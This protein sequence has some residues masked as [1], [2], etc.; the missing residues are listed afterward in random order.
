MND[1]SIYRSAISA[2]VVLYVAARLWRLTDSCLWFDEIFSVHAAE[3]SWTG[4][5]SFVAVDLIH[6]P[7]FYILLKGWIGIGGESLPWLRSLPV[8][9]SSVALI[10][11]VFLCKEFA[12]RR[13]SIVLA[14]LFFGCNG[15]LIKYSQEVRMYGLLLCLGLFSIWLFLR[16]EKKGKGIGLLTI[17]N[18]LLVYT[19]YAG[20]LTI[21][22]EVLVVLL[23]R[24]DLAKRVILSTTLV[25][26]VFVPW[27]FAV[28]NASVGG[29]GFA[30]NIGWI[31]RPGA[32]AI[33]Q[34]LLNLCEPF[35]SQVSSIDP[36]S[37]YQVTIPILLLAAIAVT[38]STAQRRI[39][40][41]QN[42]HSLWIF[43]V[44]PIIVMFLASW[45]FPYSIWGV[46]HLIVVFPLG[47]IILAKAIEG[48]RSDWMRVGCIT[49]IVLFIGYGSV[50]QIQRAA[51]PQIWCAWEQ[52]AAQIPQNRQPQRL[53]VFEDLNA[54]HF[55]FATRRRSDIQIIKVNDMPEMIEDK[56]YFLPRGFSG[57]QTIDREAIAGDHFWIAFRDMKWDERHPPLNI[58]IA[59]GY[60]IGQPAWVDAQGLKAFLAEVSR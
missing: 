30:Q 14:I 20:W 15:S 43:A 16:L 1:R 44:S 6:P 39:A 27:L 56:A 35:Y 48:L 52:L 47:A 26:A 25:L 45:I 50:R 2:S 33:F 59:R 24:R 19:H 3:H 29:G 49:L 34:L 40:S 42:S 57:V 5:L 54:Y 51:E 17:V 21:G 11:F 58:L 7:L 9:F 53:Y 23:F 60:H 12:L 18:I 55:W 28:C 31:E 22:S 4:L 10:P 46:R 8:I 41:D 37:I 32:P 36:I 38:V 13:W